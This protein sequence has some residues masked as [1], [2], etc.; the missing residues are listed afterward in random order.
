MMGLRPNLQVISESREEES[1]RSVWKI[2]LW[3]ALSV[4]SGYL[5]VASFERWILT[6]NSAYFWS[7][8]VT[9]VLF[10]S[11]AT[12]QVFFVKSAWKLA[13]I[14][15]LECA[16]PLL[17]FWNRLY[18]APSYV[19]LGGAGAAFILSFFALRRGRSFAQNSVE[20]RFFDVAKVF[21]PRFAAAWLVFVSVLFYLSFFNWGYFTPA[22]KDS[23]LGSLVSAAAPAVNVFVPGFS[24]NES[25]G[26][27][28]Q[29]VAKSGLQNAQYTPSGVSAKNFTVAFSQL[30]EKQQAALI[31]EAT[32]QLSQ[33][34]EARFG[35]FDPNETMLQF[36]KDLIANYY[37]GIAAKTG[38]ATSIVI[39]AAAFF[40]MKGIV[41][42]FYWLIAFIAFVV[43]KLMM[44]FGFSRTSIES[45]SREFV[46]LS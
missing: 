9:A 22:L 32:D 12:L 36:S 23:L 29:N 33:T 20:L 5:F 21:L 38:I 26:D 4:A 28:L 35:K 8:I 44:V 43:F 7:L 2:L 34:F 14:T 6:F 31:S 25:V 46:L 24:T 41:A 42:L 27:F 37:N 18:P 30:P 11:F 10:W 40:L 16:V 45:R 19:L 1:D 15:L 39:A 17:I 13:L 3:G